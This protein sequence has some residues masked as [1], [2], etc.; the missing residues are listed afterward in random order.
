MGADS[1]YEDGMRKS[2]GPRIRALPLFHDFIECD[3]VLHLFARARNLHGKH[4]MVM[5]KPQ[6]FFV[7]QY[8]YSYKITVGNKYM[9]A[10][11]V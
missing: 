5:K 2:L 1:G 11:C 3:A 7:P 8:G 6:Q 10:V 4:G 9:S